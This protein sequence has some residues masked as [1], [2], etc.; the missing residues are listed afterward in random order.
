MYFRIHKLVFRLLSPILSWLLSPMSLAVSLVKS[1]SRRANF[2]SLISKCSVYWYTRVLADRK[3]TRPST[4]HLPLITAMFYGIELSGSQM[5][6]DIV[7]GGTGD[8]LLK[9]LEILH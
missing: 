6:G 3:P 5:H 9:T 2:G 4:T 8:R 7:L 1:A